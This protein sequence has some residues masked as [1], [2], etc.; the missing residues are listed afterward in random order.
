MLSLVGPSIGAAEAELSHQDAVAEHQSESLGS[1]TSLYFTFDA[2][3]NSPETN[4]RFAARC[5][6]AED[7][8]ANLM[9]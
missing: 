3:R 8:P 9:F 7:S 1:A 5:S 4:V 2:A 6:A